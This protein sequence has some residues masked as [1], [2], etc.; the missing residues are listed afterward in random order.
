MKKANRHGVSFLVILSVFFFSCKSPQNQEQKVN[1][2]RQL[3]YET[4]HFSIYSESYYHILEVNTPFVGGEFSEQYVFYPKDS[5]KPT[6]SAIT[7]FIKTPVN[8]VVTTS[9]KS[10]TS[11]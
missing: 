2:A 3:L 10:Y 5:L 1:A 8:S 6:L 4:P 9:F 7:H 11:W